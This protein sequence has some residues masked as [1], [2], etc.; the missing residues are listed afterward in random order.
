LNLYTVFSVSPGK[1]SDN[2]SSMTTYLQPLHIHPTKQR[3][4]TQTA[5]KST[6]KTA[7]TVIK[8]GIQ[9]LDNI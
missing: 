8:G 9:Y 6:T 5:K 1:I 2:L 4:K 7:K 3:Y